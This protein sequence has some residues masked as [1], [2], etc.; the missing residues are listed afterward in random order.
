M[1]R[2][3]GIQKSIFKAGSRTYYRSS[4]YFPKEIR[5]DVTTLYA[6]VRVVDDMVDSLPQ[7][8]AEFQAFRKD[9]REALKGRDSINPLIQNFVDLARRRHFDPAWAEA[10]FSSME[11]DLTKRA[12]QSLD[13]LLEYTYG[14]AEVIGL[15][16]LKIMD[17][18]D[19]ASE[20]ARALGRA[21]Q[22]INFI[23]D[24]AEDFDLGRRYLPLTEGLTHLSR[25]EA[26]RHPE[27]FCRFI[28]THGANF[29]Q[30]MDQAREA[31]RFLPRRVLI[32]VATASDLYE[33]T[34]RTIMKKPHL[35]WTKKVKPG[36]L[37]ILKVYWK[38]RLTWK[39][40]RSPR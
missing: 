5:Q 4:Q 8:A 17:L 23:R 37:T 25:E 19:E 10:F 36:Q 39:K 3:S 11:A 15:F 2:A 6:F 27:E 13:E 33:W 34:C 16:M 32:P 40:Y 20:G 14:S 22:Y 26:E 35:V 12:Y 21:M 7:Q 9:Y 28:R 38:N 30:A 1:E 18:P 29:L 31:F 24:I